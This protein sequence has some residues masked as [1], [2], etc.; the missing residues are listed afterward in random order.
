MHDSNINILNEL[1][2]VSNFNG[3]LTFFF[4]FLQRM[5]YS[6]GLKMSE[7]SHC[8]RKKRIEL[9]GLMR[10]KAIKEIVEPQVSQI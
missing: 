10:V 6:L 1:A 3:E 8:V 2:I 4:F 9:Q 7:L 5:F